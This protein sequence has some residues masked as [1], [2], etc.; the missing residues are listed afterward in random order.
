MDRAIFS[1]QTP[2][3]AQE[4]LRLHPM[5]LAFVGD[6]VQSLY[7]RTRVTL[8]SSAKT[9]VLH[10]E[11]IKVVKAVSQAAIAE[12]LMP[13]FNDAEA[14]LFRRARSCHVQTS[15]KHAEQCQYRKASGLEAVIGYLYITQQTD[16]LL[17]FL[18]LSFE[19]S[20]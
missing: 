7:A 18:A 5:S 9:G 6:A 2:C 1:I 16:R 8:G 4:A 15:A 19:E 10:R 12:K 13:M 3:D 14:D 11:V 17:Q 20:L